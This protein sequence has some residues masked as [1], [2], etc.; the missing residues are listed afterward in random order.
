[1]RENIEKS[2]DLNCLENGYGSKYD[3]YGASIPDKE[4]LINIVV[5]N[6]NK[7]SINY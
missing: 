6:N 1:M 2:A 7:Y 4:G 5:Y 3:N